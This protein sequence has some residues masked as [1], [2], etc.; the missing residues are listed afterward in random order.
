MEKYVVL[1]EFGEQQDIHVE[2]IRCKKM[3]NLL[4]CWAKK[5]SYPHI[6]IK[7]KQKLIENIKYKRRVLDIDLALMNGTHNLYSDFYTVNGI[8]VLVYAIKIG[9]FVAPSNSY[10]ILGFYQNWDFMEEKN[11][12]SPLEALNRISIL[13]PWKEFSKEEQFETERIVNS[14]N[15]LNCVIHNL[16]WNFECSILGNNLKVYIVKS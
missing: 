13:I 3:E 9:N 12:T 11:Y 5:I 4:F 7:S 8:F 1:T 16:V 6:G 14:T 10:V 15:T 2:T